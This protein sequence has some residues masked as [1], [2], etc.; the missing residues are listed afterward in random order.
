MKRPANNSM[1][2]MPLKEIKREETRLPKIS[3]IIAVHNA[4]PFLP[5][6][7]EG[8]LAQS[9][10]G[11]M[12]VSIRLDGCTDGSEFICTKF[13]SD[14]AQEGSGRF[15]CVISAVERSQG[16]GAARNAAVEQSSGDIL[17]VHDADDVSLPRRIELQVKALN[18]FPEALVGS[19]F[20]RIPQDATARYT[21][22]CNKIDERS[23]YLQ[24]FREL[25]II[26]PT[27]A[28]TRKTFEAAGRYIEY[29]EDGSR[30]LA[31]DMR[32]FFAHLDRFFHDVDECGIPKKTC[33][34]KLEEVLLKYRHLPGSISGQ[35]PRKL[36]FRIKAAA[37]ERTHLKLW[38]KFTI[39]NAGRDGRDLIKNLSE[40]TQAEKVRGFCD[41]DPKKIASGY[42]NPNLARETYPVV[43]FTQAQSPIVCCV[44]MD[45]GGEFEAN[46]ASLKLTEGKDYVHFC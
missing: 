11:E 24:R 20:D 22:W 19:R 17:C 18:R 15:S 45:R 46:L 12:E 40:R 4:E 5:E 31:E 25:T 1:Q 7:F 37:L 34:L 26:Q 36:L 9:Y 42:S 43:H 3:I 38:E 13:G 30:A 39:W 6:A 14:L 16:S 2:S 10:L 21:K 23:I 33:L 29:E 32:F 44:A 27:W 41:I 35:T 8:I 28:M